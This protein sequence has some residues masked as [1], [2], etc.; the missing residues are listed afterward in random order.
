MKIVK[1]KI[2]LDDETLK[3]Y[4]NVADIAGVPLEEFISDMFIGYFE[5]QKILP[6][7]GIDF[8]GGRN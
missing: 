1:I 8:D 7:L 2:C 5:V 6:K 4:Q 3:F